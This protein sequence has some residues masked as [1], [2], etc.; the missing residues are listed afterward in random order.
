MYKENETQNWCDGPSKKKLNKN[1]RSYRWSKRGDLTLWVAWPATNPISSLFYFFQLHD[2]HLMFNYYLIILCLSHFFLSCM[3]KIPY[4]SLIITFLLRQ[5]LAYI[6]ANK[7]K[8]TPSYRHTN[9]SS[10]TMHRTQAR[11]N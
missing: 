10:R 3:L 11:T 9:F 1:Y 4:S 2:T 5:L 7:N 6:K 8:Y